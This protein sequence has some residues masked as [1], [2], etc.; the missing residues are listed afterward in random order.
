MDNLYYAY[1]NLG[2]ITKQEMIK[3]GYPWFTWRYIKD[4]VDVK[5]SL[6]TYDNLPDED[7]TSEILETAL[8]FNNRLCFYFVSGLQTWKLCKFIPDGA[9]N[10]YYKPEYV[11]I[12]SLQGNHT[13]GTHVPYKD[14]ILVKDNTMDIIPFLVMNEY[15]TKIVN[16]E[17]TIEKV[18]TLCSL[19]LGLVGSKKQ[20]NALKQVARQMGTKDP[21]IVGDDMIGDI[22]SFA[23]NV[24]VKPAEVYEL[25]HKYINE[26][27]AS[28]GIY[29]VDEKRER[30]V[31]QEL[32][33][34]NDF[35]DTTYQEM[36]NERQRFIKELNARGCN[37]K[38]RETYKKVFHESVI[39]AE[40]LAIANAGGEKNMEDKENVN[41]LS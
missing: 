11:N 39:E 31:T 14:I 41:K 32:L 1:A 9:F 27:R 6:F 15:I 23:I 36:V 5:V 13:Y 22:K 30:I 21:F 37:V 28:I 38:L 20:A 29:S 25:R 10:D 3:Q 40:Q 7:L 4:L 35:S 16:I 17:N 2:S 34:L 12:I 8:M 18:L 24:P 26:A 33:N 19:P